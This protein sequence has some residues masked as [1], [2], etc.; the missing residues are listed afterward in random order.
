MLSISELDGDIKI[1]GIFDYE[2]NSTLEYN[3]SCYISNGNASKTYHTVL[4]IFVLDVDDNAPYIQDN[5]KLFQELDVT[6]VIPVNI[7]FYYYPY[8]NFN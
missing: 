6:Q 2:K 5:T 1:S 8:S 3:V 4:E 7:I